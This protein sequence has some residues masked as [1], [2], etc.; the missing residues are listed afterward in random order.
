M[1]RRALNR[2]ALV[3]GDRWGHG[4]DQR[5]GQQRS[6]HGSPRLFEGHTPHVDD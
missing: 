6:V 2:V 3:S 5:E 4:S 1:T